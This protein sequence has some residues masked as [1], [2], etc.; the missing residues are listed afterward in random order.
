MKNLIVYASTHG[1]T[2]KCAKKVGEG[3]DG[4]SEVIPVRQVKVRDLDAYER[5]LIGGSI[6]AGRIQKSIRRF[7][8]NHIESL[9]NKKVGLFLC[10]M[11]EGESAQKQFDNAYPERLR[12]HAV[13]TG[14]FGGKFDFDRMKTVEKF[15]VKRVA[16]VEESVSNISDKRIADFI[17]TMNTLD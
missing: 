4:E 2:E 6:H 14:L 8:E 3:L 7:C 11:E 1:C 15:I 17:K 9:L 16:H 5:I 13:T 10:C 12:E